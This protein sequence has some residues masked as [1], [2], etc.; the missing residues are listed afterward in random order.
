M[1]GVA[2]PIMVKILG[3]RERDTD[4]NLESTNFSGGRHTFP[5][6]E[7]GSLAHVVSIR[8]CEAEPLA[9]RATGQAKK[10]PTPADVTGRSH[11][12]HQ[13]VA[14]KNDGYQGPGIESLADRR[15]NG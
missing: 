13:H 4:S 11:H 7:H 1:K 6:C 3:A 12:Q 9:W 5:F 2:S 8:G 10:P 14:S 15:L